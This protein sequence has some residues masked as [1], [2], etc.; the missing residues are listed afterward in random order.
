[1]KQAGVY[2]YDGVKSVPLASW[3]PLMDDDTHAV[4]LSPAAAHCYIPYVYRGVD[5]R[6]KLVSAMPWRLVRA[7]NGRGKL[8]DGRDVSHLPEYAPLVR[9][10]RHRL[11]IT[12]ASLCLYGAAYWVKETDRRRRIHPRFLLPMSINPIYDGYT[13]L[14]GFERTDGLGMRRL[15]LDDVVYIWQPS[16]SV[17]IGPGVAPVE[18]AL[19]A[20]GVLA[21]LAEFTAGYFKRGAV[22]ATLLTVENNPS[23]EELTRL[24]QW[25]RRLVS[26]VRRSWESVAI[27][28]T[29]KP[30]VIGDGLEALAHKPLTD[31]QRQDICAALGVPHSLIAAD[32]ANYATAQQHWLEVHEAT[33]T[34]EALLI[35]DALNEQL[36][37][38]LGLCFEFLPH[39]LE[40][41]QYAQLEMATRVMQLVGNVL[42]V[43]EAR[44]LMGY[45]PAIDPAQR[46]REIERERLQMEHLRLRFEGDRLRLEEQAAYE[47]THTVNEVR[48]TWYEE[49]PLWDERGVMLVSDRLVAQSGMGTGASVEA[50]QQQ[51]MQQQTEFDSMY[52]IVSGPGVGPRTQASVAGDEEDDLDMQQDDLDM[53]QDDLDPYED[54]DASG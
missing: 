31:E 11:Y 33:V 51:A 17:E 22:K 18:V 45:D 42:T 1:M 35:Q 14:L 21:N 15:G 9:G 8:T 27:R 5:M 23:K 4:S 13:G 41:Y 29:V 46:E 49:K 12:E 32:A 25:W 16:M 54:E 34:P 28:S 47:R 43:P 30:V 44:E 52:E 24:E 39:K 20:A 2:A 19:R 10:M 37:E 36:F 50:R 53:G 26:G 7:T 38:P 3:H 40:V 6:A 48:E